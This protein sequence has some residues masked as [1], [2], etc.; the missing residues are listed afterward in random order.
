MGWQERL[1]IALLVAKYEVDQM[2]I[3]LELGGSNSI[4]NLCALE[5]GGSNSIR[6]LWSESANPRGDFTRSTA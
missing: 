3:A 4:R 2:L 5:L 6:N 1:A